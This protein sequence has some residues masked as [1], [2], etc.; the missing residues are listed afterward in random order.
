MIKGHKSWRKEKR[1]NLFVRSNEF[2]I[3]KQKVSRLPPIEEKNG[4]PGARQ[5]GVRVPGG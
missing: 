3:Q 2:G 5:I 1:E 4:P